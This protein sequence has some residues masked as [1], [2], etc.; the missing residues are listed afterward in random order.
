M[1]ADAVETLLFMASPNNS[2]YHPPS[3]TSQES[4]LRSTL[5]AQTSPLRAQFSQTNVT[6]PKKVAFSDENGSARFRTREAQI[7]HEL[8]IL[9]DDSEE[10]SEGVTLLVDRDLA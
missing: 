4:S 9:A 3:Q 10:E 1:E 8:D 2:G 7:D 5:I 6:S